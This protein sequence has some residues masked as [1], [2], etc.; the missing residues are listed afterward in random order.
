MLIKRR[1]VGH[2]QISVLTHLTDQA[3]VLAYHVEE[4]E[5]ERRRRRCCE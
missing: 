2:G 4:E 3:E 1:E 5:E